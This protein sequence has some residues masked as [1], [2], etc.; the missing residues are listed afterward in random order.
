MAKILRKLPQRE[1]GK[2]AITG[3]KAD[4]ILSNLYTVDKFLTPEINN[5]MSQLSKDEQEELIDYFK[6]LADG[7]NF[8]SCTMVSFDNLNGLNVAQNAE[9]S[10]LTEHFT[11]QQ[12][13]LLNQISQNTSLARIL[14]LTTKYSGYAMIIYA[15]VS[16]YIKHNMKILYNFIYPKD[17]YVFISIAMVAFACIMSQEKLANNVA[18]KIEKMIDM[19]TR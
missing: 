10:G 18:K 7:L 14:S 11:R 15:I 5:D 1:H 16:F 19:N 9:K 2:Y 6:D 3:K 17:I 12:M 4:E 8:L 13:N